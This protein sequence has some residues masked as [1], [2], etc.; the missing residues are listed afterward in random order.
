MATPAHV[1]RAVSPLRLV[2]NLCEALDRERIAYCHWK[3]NAFVD[4]SARGEND[5]D[6]LV[7][8][9]DLDAFRA[10]L[11]GLR[12]KEAAFAARSIPGVRSYYGFDAEAD[13]LVHVHAHTQLLVGDDLTK[14]VRLPLEAAFLDRPLRE[15]D[16]PVPLPE[17]ELIALVV[18]MVL[19]H[20][21]WEAMLARRDRISRSARDEL[22]FLRARVDEELL[23]SLLGRHLPLVNHGL[24][25][26]C[27][28]ALEPT[29]GRV[30]R[31]RAARRLTTALAP[32]ARRSRGSDVWAK[33]WRHAAAIVRSR[34]GIRTPRRQLAGGGALIALVGADGAGKSTLLEAL[35][36]WLSRHFAVTAVHLGRPP[37]SATTLAVRIGL[38]LRT[39]VVRRL[40]RRAT[41]GGPPSLPQLLLA[42]ATARDRV[43]LHRRARRRTLNGELVLSDRFPL[44]QLTLM[45]APRIG[46]WMAAGSN[47]PL[48][49]RLAGLERRFYRSFV[50]PDILIVL[51]VDPEVAVQRKPDEEPGFVRA[52][53]QEIWAA[54]WEAAG[55]HVVDAGLP[56]EEVLAQVKALVWSEL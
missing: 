5:L 1:S 56:A 17:L 50:P 55:A 14:N 23:A 13:R 51:R 33:L 41:A 18:R 4:R 21:T 40:G 54:D 19:K 22:A 28:H 35:D 8:R 11:H 20:A 31:I 53:W 42:V 29:S 26:D 48:A 45:D 10:V 37:W 38:K 25:L 24:F 30:E 49:R 9:T 36:A 2:R 39:A 52:R 34:L 43:R 12:F 44:P 32:Y 3:S 47:T 7:R 16:F 27:Q 46:R 15:G 6:L